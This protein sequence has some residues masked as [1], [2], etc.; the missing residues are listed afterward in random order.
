MPSNITQLVNRKCSLNLCAQCN[1][2][3]YERVK[4]TE[5]PRDLKASFIIDKFL[6]SFCR[7]LEIVIS[8]VVAYLTEQGFMGMAQIG[9]SFSYYLRKSVTLAYNIYK[10]GLISV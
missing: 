3:A 2:K 4:G 7:A 9:S 1:G 5:N 8:A 10:E 6:M